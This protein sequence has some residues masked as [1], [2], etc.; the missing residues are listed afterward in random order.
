[1]IAA[2]GSN[3]N[4]V[5]AYRI[6]A[7]LMIMSVLPAKFAET[8]SASMTRIFAAMMGSAPMDRFVRMG[9]AWNNRPNADRTQTVNLVNSVSVVP[10]WMGR[11][12]A[13]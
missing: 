9:I 4:S 1:M 10:V 7:A 5:S 13:W 8:V 11:R 2:S 12:S 3:V 6:G